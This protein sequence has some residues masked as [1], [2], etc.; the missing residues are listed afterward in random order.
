MQRRILKGVMIVKM[1]RK[2]QKANQSIVFESVRMQACL[3]DPISQMT[4]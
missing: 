4:V 3:Y 2:A 1:S